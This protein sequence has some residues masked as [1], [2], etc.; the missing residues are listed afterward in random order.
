MNQLLNKKNIQLKYIFVGIRNSFMKKQAIILGLVLAITLVKVF[1]FFPNAVEDY[2][3][4]GWY[5][6]LSV[7]LRFLWGWIPFS[8]GDVLYTFAG[9]W[10]LIQL[11]NLI[12]APRVQLLNFL[13]KTTVF[14]ATLYLLFYI[15]WGLNYYRIPIKDKW[16]LQG[17]YTFEELV[18]LTEKLI[19]KSNRM[20]LK[21]TKNVQARVNN[22]Y[23]HAQIFEKAH[24]GYDA[25][26][27]LHPDLAFTQY[28]SKKSLYSLPLT[29]MGFGGYLNPF[30]NEA[31]VNSLLP[32][33]NFPTTT[34]HEMA[35]QW[36]IAP[37][38]EANL[39]GHLASV[40]HPDQYFKYSGYT[41]ALRYCLSEVQQLDEKKYQELEQKINPGILKNFAQTEALWQQYESPIETISK[42]IY[43]NYLEANQQK[44]GMKTYH[45]FVGL[46]IQY[47]KI[48]PIKS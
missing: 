30:T 11:I 40:H 32:L 20:Q 12:K 45:A 26:K 47:Y 29:Y 7:S 2:Y 33:Y 10:F 28:S 46:M 43:G 34:C 48:H 25:L 1:S 35:H 42:N 19:V 17:E 31:Q 5:P 3:S 36:G 9:I 22:P 44:G 13:F 39:I 4:H 21:I 27:R 23:T 6:T 41:Y 14:G 38:S 15:F 18:H 8:V 37:E 16:Q 24:L